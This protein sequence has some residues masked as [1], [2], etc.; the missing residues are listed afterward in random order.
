MYV[1]TLYIHVLYCYVFT[2]LKHL[3]MSSFIANQLKTNMCFVSV[4]L[5]VVHTSALA[6]VSSNSVILV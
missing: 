2:F 1:H 6:R 3:N 5:F 4:K